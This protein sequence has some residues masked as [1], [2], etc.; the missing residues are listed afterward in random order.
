MEIKLKM[1]AEEYDTYRAYQRDRNSLD[2]EIAKELQQFMNKCEDVC[3]SVLDAIEKRESTLYANG[4]PVE[5]VREI[6][7]R[8]EE[9][10]GKAIDLAET[11]LEEILRRSASTRAREVTP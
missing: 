11:T 10:A 9:L 4:Q 3:T 7:I 5:T 2:R 6:R 8:D 1:T